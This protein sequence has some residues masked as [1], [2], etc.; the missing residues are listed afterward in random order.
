MLNNKSNLSKCILKS[1][2]RNLQLRYK[3]SVV[4]ENEY[5]GAIVAGHLRCSFVGE[6]GSDFRLSWVDYNLD[7]SAPMSF[8][9]FMAFF[10]SPWIFSF[11]VINAVAGLRL[12]VTMRLITKDGLVQL[13]M[14]NPA[15]NR[16]TG[17]LACL[18][19]IRI[20]FIN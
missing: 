5:Y 9:S 8:S 19:W 6:V 14:V 15:F 2:K 10:M 1:Y 18:A 13:D 16:L 7:F 4:V 3:K 12:P 17:R 20:T 11:P